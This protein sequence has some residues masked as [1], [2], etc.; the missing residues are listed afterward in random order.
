MRIHDLAQQLQVSTA[1]ISR[2]LNRPESVRP[3]TRDRVL[4]AIAASGYQLNGI[5]RSLRTQRTRTI[6]LIVS[7]IRNPFFSTIAKAV[8]DVTRA[9]Q[10]TLLVCNAD[11]DGQHE[12]AALRLLI[13]CRISGLI[14]C[15]VGTSPSL[16]QQ[17]QRQSTPIV[18][19]DRRSDV[20]DVDAVLLDN[21]LGS[22][23]AA[24]H[25]IKLGHRRIAIVAGPKHLSSGRTRLRGFHRALRRAGVPL[26]EHF[27]QY[28][29]FR[30]ESGF[31]ATECLFSGAE[32]P[33]A[34][35][36]CNGE[37]MAGAL[38]YLREKRI[39]IPRNASVV[40]F[41]DVRWARYLQPPLTV[42]A[43]PTEEMGRAAAELL[44]ARLDAPKPVLFRP[45]TRVFPPV[46]IVRGSTS[47]ATNQGR[48]V[49]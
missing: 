35:F 16:I 32:R 44:L 41:D 27:V 33:T 45:I 2:A 6:G 34:L 12:A 25:L 5:A 11:E 7:D 49:G 29:D 46:L 28:G 40:C 23:L 19:L 21:E 30:E 24:N 26:P 18:D 8:E 38:A 31:E 9:H 10:Y 20:P 39:A 17:L 36:V 14:H 43:Q 3:A 1:T 37:M 4:A 48:I 13:E 42:I 22:T 15:S 47:R